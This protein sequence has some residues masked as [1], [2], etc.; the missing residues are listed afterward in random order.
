MASGRPASTGRASRPRQWRKAHLGLDADTMEVRA[1]E[2]TG[3][4]VGDA[5]MLPR[6]LNQIPLGD[7]VGTATAGGACDTR[8]SHAA[9]AAR[10]A[11]AV[12]P[13]RRNGRPWKRTAPRA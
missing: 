3:G 13:V 4:R 9:I 8:T 6:L 7:T 1:V 12:V 11:R 10:P 2:A 5:P